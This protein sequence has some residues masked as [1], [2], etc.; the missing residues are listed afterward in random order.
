MKMPMLKL[1]CLA[2]AVLVSVSAGAQTINL[3][4]AIEMSLTADPRIKEQ[5]QVVE[6]ARALLEE[7]RANN[8][9]R[10]ELNT[11]IGLAP[12]VKGGFFENGATSGTR[13]RSD[14]PFPGGVSDWTFLQF[15][16][17]KPLYSFGKIE[18]Y[19]EAAQ[20]NIDVK[21]TD[22]RVARATTI[23]DVK[24]AY[25][26]YLAARDTRR[27]LEDLQGKVSEALKLTEKR[28]SE[29]SGEVKKSDVYALQAGKGVINKY[30][31]QALALERVS[32][33]GLKVLTGVG[34]DGKLEI[35]EDSISAL[36]KP[37]LSLAEYQSKAM[38]ERPEF[39]QLDAGLRARRALVAAKKAEMYPNIYAGLVGSFAYASRR[40]R[41][42]NPYLYDPFNHAG[43][44][45]VVGLKWDVAFDVVPAR[46]AHAQAELDAL[47]YKNQY[48]L[49]G[50]PF[51]VAESYAQVEAHYLAVQEMAEAA[52]AARRWMVATYADFNAG[53]ERADKLAEAFRSYALTQAEYL[54]TVNDYNMHVAQL[55]KVTGDYK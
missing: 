45:P 12:A 43:V 22:V 48:A 24:R 33:N 7:A 32:L 16:L 52:Q 31:A 8:G 18:R 15:N 49:A 30:H 3:N 54:R 14:G 39:S 5:E 26:G 50:I 46:V 38:A 37:S 9:L 55:T 41:L 1:S 27:L 35:A 40:E 25:F 42:D 28:L 36:P 23:M 44:T 34:L 17:V 11:F 19:S 20:G 53:L 4:Q 29:E 10:L 2:A 6:Q 47:L 51:E 13:L 21:R